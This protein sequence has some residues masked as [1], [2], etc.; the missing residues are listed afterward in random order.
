MNELPSVVVI[1]AALISGMILGS[2]LS[3]NM[4]YKLRG[5]RE[6]LFTILRTK[7][8]FGIA[9]NQILWLL[10]VSIAMVATAVFIMRMGNV[11]PLSKADR[12]AFVILWFISIACAKYLRYCYW[13]KKSG[14]L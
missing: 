5:T 11:Y 4:E 8:A 2:N 12:Y 14:K 13:K 7:S 6:P 3:T 9:L 1:L 10:I